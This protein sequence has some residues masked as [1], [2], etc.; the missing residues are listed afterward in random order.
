MH[1]YCLTNKNLSVAFLF[2]EK[3]YKNTIYYMLN[4]VLGDFKNKFVCSQ[5]PLKKVVVLQAY[6]L[7]LFIKL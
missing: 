5:Q 4:I 2:K 7:I 1:L 3:I 6:C